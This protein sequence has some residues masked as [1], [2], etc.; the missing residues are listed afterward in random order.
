MRN[1]FLA[2]LFDFSFTEFVTAKLLKVIYAA[3]IGLWTVVGLVVLVGALAQS[4]LAALGALIVVPV[5]VLV[6]VTVTRI[7]IELVIVAFRI[8]DHAAEVAEQAA[9]IAL[10]TAE[11]GRTHRPAAIGH[12]G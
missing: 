10:N 9:A 8:A 4:G 5:G 2:T 1:R 3:A 7:W 11:A 12:S 6:A